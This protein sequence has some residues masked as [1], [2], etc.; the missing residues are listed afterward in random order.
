[1]AYADAD[2]M[3]ARF[4]VRIIADLLSDNGEPVVDISQSPVLWAALDD[5]AGEIDSALTVA[6]LYTP[7]DL[8]ALEG[9][10]LALLK[11][12]NCGLAMSHLME[13]RQENIGSERIEA[14]RLAAHQFLERLRK[15]E[16]VFAC[17]AENRDAGL[18]TVD[19]PS[20]VDYEK[21]NTVVDHCRGQFYPRRRLPIGR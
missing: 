8:A 11:R 13:R 6:N 3:T 18:P 17:V 14:A 1:M 21:L 9:D 15:G 4:D 20:T 2:D 5:G 19:G 10:S 12:I 7:A 16:R